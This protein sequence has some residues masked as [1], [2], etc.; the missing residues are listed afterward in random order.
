MCVLGFFWGRKVSR[1]WC[2]FLLGCRRS[3]LTVRK[4]HRQRAHA[5]V[6][7]SQEGHREKRGEERKRGE[8]MLQVWGGKLIEMRCHFSLLVTVRAREGRGKK[9]ERVRGRE[10]GGGRL[11]EVWSH[12]GKKVGR[13]K[14]GTV[15][16]CIHE[17][18]GYSKTKRWRLTDCVCLCMQ[19]FYQMCQSYIRASMCRNA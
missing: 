15:C 17:Q 13:L 1:D 6:G 16:L 9:Q 18:G 19:G 12:L 7:H 3:K 4:W 5:V 2:M 8:Q 10:G 14:L 11:G